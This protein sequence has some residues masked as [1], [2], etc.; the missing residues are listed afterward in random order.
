MRILNKIR[1]ILYMYVLNLLK[2]ETYE[3]DFRRNFS[4]KYVGLPNA[5]RKYL[6]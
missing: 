4:M 5:K 1:K 3:E 6:Y 2:E